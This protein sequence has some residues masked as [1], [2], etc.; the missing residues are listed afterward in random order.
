MTLKERVIVEV[1]TGYVMTSPEE[2]DE[3]YKYMAEI[4]DRPVF[5]HELADKEIQ[6][7]LKEKAKPDFTGLC[8]TNEKWQAAANKVLEL[9]S[10]TCSLAE[11]TY[12]SD[13]LIRYAVGERTEELY[14][15]MKKAY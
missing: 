3:V 8:I 2:K 11:N 13:L 10:L 12:Y 4:M 6:E 15:L 7:R 5:T 14:E 9:K 1:Y